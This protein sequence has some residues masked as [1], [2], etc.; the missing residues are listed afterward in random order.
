MQLS[1]LGSLQTSVKD[2]GDQ[3][4]TVDFTR[5]LIFLGRLGNMLIYIDNIW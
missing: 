1:L 3:P 2:L 5:E 4:V